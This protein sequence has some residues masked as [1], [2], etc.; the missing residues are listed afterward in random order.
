[1][2]IITAKRKVMQRKGMLKVV[3][4]ILPFLLVA[5]QWTT[6]TVQ[7]GMLQMDVL[8]IRL[9]PWLESSYTY[10]YLHAF[11]FI[12]VFLFS[13]DRKVYY[14]RKWRY[15]LPAILVVATFFII[16][17]VFF[18]VREV[19]G[20]NEDYLTG[21][22]ILHLPVEEWLFF[23]TV[24]YA[25]V[26]IYECLNFYVKRD[27]LAPVERTITIGMI[28]VFL[29]IGLLRWSHMY[30][31]T[32][33]L[34]AGF[35]LLYHLLFLDGSYRSRFYAAYL[36]SWIP[37]LLV[38]GVLTGG[39]TAKPVVI[40]NP[41]EYLGWRITSIPIDDSIYS[42]LLLFATVSFFEF[43]RKKRSP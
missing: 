42:F 23:F 4:I 7:P 18:T 30:T 16:W 10:L 12:P 2:N 20:F 19:W 17:D 3:L 13:F 38:N 11:T 28:I 26:F 43:L 25:C 41:E 9:L 40:Y 34:L 32:V 1:M 29:L 14:Y 21:W 22:R 37:F 8:K 5:G 31:A 6:D 27:W 35:F 15:L 24:P 39:Y 36:V 33:F